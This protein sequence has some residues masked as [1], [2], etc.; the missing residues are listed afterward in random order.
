MHP[1]RNI[2]LVGFMGTGKTTIGRVL[3]DQLKCDFVDMD[4]EL[5][6]RAG[7]P[8]PRI[9]AEDGEPVFRRME[10]NLVVEL[11]RRPVRH[12]LGGGGSN[13]V[14]AAGGGI[15]LNPDNIRDFSATGHVICLKAAPDEILRRVSGSSH[16]PLLEQGD[17]GERIRKLRMAR[18][19]FYDAIPAQV[20]TTGKTINEVVVEVLKISDYSHKVFSVRCSGSEKH[21]DEP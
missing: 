8:I 19:P 2:I 17:K 11:S 6:A 5:E 3:A 4:I 1:S 20:D 16:R 10:R 21:D 12:S 13:L 15:V 9:F 14:I 7:K 18:Q